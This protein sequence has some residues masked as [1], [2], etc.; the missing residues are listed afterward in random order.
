M[1]GQPPPPFKVPREIACG[2]LGASF[3]ACLF[4]PLELVKTRLQVQSQYAYPETGALPYRGT[5]HAMRT[6]AVEEGVVALWTHGFAGFVARDF[7][8]SGLRIGLYPTVRELVSLESSGEAASLPSKIVSGCTTGI[9]GSAIATPIDVMRVRTSVESGR[10]RPAALGSRTPTFETG[11]CKGREVQFRG[12]IDCFRLLIREGG[13]VGL[14]RGWAPTCARAAALSGAQLASYDHSKVL[15]LRWGVFE[16]EGKGLHF[17]CAM[18]SGVVAA[19]A[20]NPPDVLK[21]RMMLSSAAGGAAGGG[22]Q[23]LSMLATTGSILR[24]QGVLG[25]YKGWVP[26]V[27]RAVVSQSVQMPLV[28]GLRGRAGLGSI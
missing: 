27:S 22:A 12:A 16:Q 19:T 13:L 23:R 1:S 3:T 28:E 11:L 26:A 2:S 15:L 24:Q 14:W 8:Y 18:F 7:A 10:V 21:S 4:S 17:L 20:C 9:I 5:V 25:L 6:I